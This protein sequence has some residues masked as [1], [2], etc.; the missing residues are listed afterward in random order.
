M[1]CALVLETG[2]VFIGESFGA[3]VETR[4]EVVFNTGMTG[5]QE[6]LTDPSYADQ[7]VCMTYPLVGNYGVNLADDQSDKIQV[8]GFIV[9][10]AASDPNHWQ[11]DNRLADTLTK[12]PSAFPFMAF[13]FFQPIYWPGSFRWMCR[14]S[15]SALSS[16]SSG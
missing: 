3:A 13:R 11:M 10:E 7:I 4:G 2:K 5:Y 9:K 14:F 1:Q 15:I 8:R 12:A 16:P 6:V